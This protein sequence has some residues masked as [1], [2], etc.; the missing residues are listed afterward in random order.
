MCP[1]PELHL[2]TRAVCSRRHLCGLCASFGDELT[3]FGG[4]VGT[5]GPWPDCW[6]C[7]MRQLA[8]GSW[9]SCS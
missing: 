4:L 8:L 5:T 2:V 9:R 6:A 7:V 1:S 3:A